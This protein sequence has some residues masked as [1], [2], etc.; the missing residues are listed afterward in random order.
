MRRV[1]VYFARLLV[2][3]ALLLPMSNAIALETFQKFGPISSVSHDKFTVRGVEYRIAPRATLDSNDASRKQL[4]DFKKGDKIYFEGE[5]INGIRY[6]KL[7][8]Y[9]SPIAS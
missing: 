5:I 1:T 8:T 2:V 7:V 3:T 4:S 9:E 6:V